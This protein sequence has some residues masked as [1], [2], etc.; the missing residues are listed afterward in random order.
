ML[1]IFG[2]V[3]LPVLVVAALGYLLQ[4]RMQLS[5]VPLS[6]VSIYVLQ[7]CLGCSRLYSTPTSA[8]PSRCSSCCSRR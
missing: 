3:V 5:L 1:A 4:R 2:N 6:Q 8:A 7:P